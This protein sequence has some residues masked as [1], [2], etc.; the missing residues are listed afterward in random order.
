MKPIVM[1]ISHLLVLALFIITLFSLSAQS[2]TSSQSIASGRRLY[3]TNCANCHGNAAQGAVKAGFDISIITE[4]G[5]KQPPNLTDSTWDHGS[6]DSEIFTTI[7]EGITANM[8]P[9][10]KGILKDNEIRNVISYVRSLASSTPPSNNT[11]DKVNSEVPANNQRKLELVDYLELP[12]TGDMSGDRVSGVL[13]RGSI[14]L[15]EPAG[16]RFF[17]NDLTGALYILNKQT[18]QLTPYLN[19]DGSGTKTGLFPKFTAA[20]GYA[21]GFVN[22]VFDPE[23]SK[24]GVFYTLH[25][26]NIATADEIISPKTGVVAGLNLTGY[27]TTPALGKPT[28]AGDTRF[29]REFIIIEWKDT[30]I[31]NT[32]FEGTAREVFRLQVPGLFH[33]LN[34]MTFNPNAKP[35][36]PDWRVMYLGVGDAGTGERP[37]PRR[38]YAQRLDTYQGKIL[39]IIPMLSEQ[40]GRS[41]ISETGQYRIPND[42]PFLSV[43]GAKKEIWAYGL[44]N[45]HRLTWYKNPLKPKESVL[46]AFNIGLVSWETVMII[47]KGANYGYPLREG[48][49]SMSESNIM[50]SLPADDLIPVMV[51]DSITK[52]KMKPDY[53]VIAYPHAAGGG[54]AIANGFVYQGKNIPS[55]KGTFVFAD[56]TTGRIWYSYLKDILAADDGNPLTMAPIHELNT[57][58]RPMVEETYKKRGGRAEGLPGR[59]AVAGAGRIDLRLAEDK[60]GELYAITKGDGMIRKFMSVK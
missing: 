20:M 31:N 29:A 2:Q 59:G 24:N 28:V 4:R 46:L 30:Q 22:F 21:A 17:L 11:P 56:V 60:D 8:M 5:G 37:G 52:G 58:L 19:F 34:E 7:K 13:A 3:N 57:N 6:K 53:A 26:E 42:N 40:V 10:Y 51:T 23:Y 48:A 25:M 15:E 9:S 18:K 47:K 27:T 54:D 16:N 1:K 32:T 12:I 44:R 49:Q 41:T 55:L 33:P 14:M 43:E 39:R 38:L 50:G 36:D 35:G 45:P